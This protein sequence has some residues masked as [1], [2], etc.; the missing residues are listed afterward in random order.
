MKTVDQECCPKFEPERWDERTFNWEKKHFIKESIPTFFH[1]PFPKMIGKKVTIMMDLAKSADSLSE[2]ELDTLLLFN[3]PT[4]F[5]SDI[6]MSVNHKVSHA[7]NVTLSGKFM[8]KTFDGPYKKVPKFLKEMDDY[9]SKQN[10]K[11]MDY[12]VHYAYCPKC[13]KKF[14]HNYMAI[15]AELEN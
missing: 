6:Y 3:D 2:D 12:Y 1:M 11:A 4:A 10:K 9:L 14:E 5:R 8:S 13:A 7:N 15:F